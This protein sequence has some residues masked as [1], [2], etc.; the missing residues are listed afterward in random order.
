[1]FPCS[2][3]NAKNPYLATMSVNRELHDGGDRSCMHVEMDI[4]G[5]G[6]LLLHAV[7]P[8]LLYCLH[9]IINTL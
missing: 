8:D 7:Q 9:V 3:F 1:M 2:P 4:A 5:T 6:L